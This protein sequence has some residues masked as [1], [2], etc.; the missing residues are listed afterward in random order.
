MLVLDSEAQAQW[1]RARVREGTRAQAQQHLDREIASNTITVDPDNGRD[2]TNLLAQLGRPMTAESVMEKLKLC[3]PKLVFER[4]IA[5][6]NLYGV[7]ILHWEKDVTGGWV[8][9]KKHICGME[10]GIM[11]E[12]NVIHQTTKKVT[13][14]ELLGAEKPTR[15]I[16]WKEI[17]TYAGETRGWRTVLIRLLNGRFINRWQVEKYFGWTPSQESEK[18]H[19]YTKGA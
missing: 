18:W 3:N 8:E 2:V 19:G 16:D 11:P 6:P 9:R 5:Y 17:P 7:Y 14:P 10:S 1:D 13:N 15:D 12:F 4:S